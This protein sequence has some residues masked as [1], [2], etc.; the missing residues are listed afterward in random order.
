MAQSV[1]VT[2]RRL[3]RDSGPARKGQVVLVLDPR[4]F[5]SKGENWLNHI[6]Y[7]TREDALA[8]AKKAKATVIASKTSKTLVAA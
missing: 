4:V 7:D 5:G 6:A 2:L 8:A 1:T 3:A